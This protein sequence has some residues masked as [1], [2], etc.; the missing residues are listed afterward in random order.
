MTICATAPRPRLCAAAA[1]VAGN[2]RVRKSLLPS[3]FRSVYLS[4]VVGYDPL[5]SN[6]QVTCVVCYYI[7]DGGYY[8][9]YFVAAA[10]GACVSVGDGGQPQP[11]PPACVR[12]RSIGAAAQERDVRC[13]GE[14]Q[15]GTGGRPARCW[16][17]GIWFCTVWYLIVVLGR[18]ASGGSAARLG[19]SG[20]AAR[21][22]DG[23]GVWLLL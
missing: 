14:K 16:C 11:L 10:Q 1:R 18:M 9:T 2:E 13:G 3:K 23:D 15:L 12:G 17:G 4:A 5:I 7:M 21:C 8:E 22:D 6:K 19:G 20:R